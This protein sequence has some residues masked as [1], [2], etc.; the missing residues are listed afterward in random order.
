MIYH[1]IANWGEYLEI[2]QKN[3]RNN[4]AAHEKRLT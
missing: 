2:E 1:F 3:R 4:Y